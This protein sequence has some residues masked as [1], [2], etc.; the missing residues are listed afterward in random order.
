MRKSEFHNNG[1]RGS[2]PAIQLA[3]EEPENWGVCWI[4]SC[5]QIRDAESCA[6]TESLASDRK[7]H[8][9]PQTGENKPGGQAIGR[10]TVA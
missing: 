10:K 5:R 3:K 1:H 9:E 7:Q 8:S 2:S 6:N 4:Q